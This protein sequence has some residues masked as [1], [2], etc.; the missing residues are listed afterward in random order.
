MVW[1]HECVITTARARV[2]EAMSKSAFTRASSDPPAW[3]GR[4]MGGARSVW[5]VGSKPKLLHDG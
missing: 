3:G 2:E 5:R 1:H 4:V